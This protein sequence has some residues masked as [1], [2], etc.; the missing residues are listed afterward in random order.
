MSGEERLKRRRGRPSNASIRMKNLN[1]EQQ[2]TLRLEQQALDTL[3]SMAVA[4][5]VIDYNL[6]NLVKNLTKNQASS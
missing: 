2:N 4:I 5:A 1:A 3:E 6:K